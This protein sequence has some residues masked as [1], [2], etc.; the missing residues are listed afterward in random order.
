MCWGWRKPVF[1]PGI[2]L[3][4]TYWFPAAT[5]A[6]I[7]ALFC[8]GIPAANLLGSP[9]S[10]WLLGIET[11]GLHGWQWMYILEGIPTLLLGFAVLIWMPDNPAKASWLT[12][13]EK[14]AVL[15]RLAAD[16]KAEVHGLREMVKDWRVWALMIPDFCIV[17]GIYALGLWMPHHGQGDGLFQFADQLCRDGALCLFAGRPVGLRCRLRP[18]RQAGAAFLP[19][20]AAGVA[21]FRHRG[22]RR[23]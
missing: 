11:G 15:A 7:L 5:R 17:F 21:G 22:H 3:Y 23:Q 19:V 20:V 8:M 14:E 10:G 4:F 6:R 1:Y 2:L 16:P 18:Q 12:A 9:L 13:S